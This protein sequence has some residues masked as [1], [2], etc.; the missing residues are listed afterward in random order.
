MAGV[1]V[2]GID[3]LFCIRR[4]WHG[5]TRVRNITALCGIKR[6]G[7]AGNVAGVLAWRVSM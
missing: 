2:C 7:V 3:V 6:D 5:V 4:T 1:S